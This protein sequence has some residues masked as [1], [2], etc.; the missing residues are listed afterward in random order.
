MFVMQKNI[1][2][3]GQRFTREQTLSG[4]EEIIGK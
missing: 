2:V 4:I 3:E 1:G